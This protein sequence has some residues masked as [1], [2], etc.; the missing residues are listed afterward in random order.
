MFKIHEQFG[1]RI[2]FPESWTVESAA[3]GRWPD[4]VT[5]QSPGSAFFTLTTRPPEA[6]PAEL[7]ART[8]A[9]LKELYEDLE[10]HPVREELADAELRG[11]DI[12]FYCLDFL[13]GA[14]LRVFSAHG[15][16][17]MVLCQAEDREFDELR[18]VFQAMTLG[19]LEPE[20]IAA[21]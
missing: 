14:S 1:V 8:L 12:N 10:A 3:D 7:L 9:A 19:V 13:V 20:R 6:D 17:F 11:F 4:A 18:P 2:P 15:Q 21:P 5:L 16:E